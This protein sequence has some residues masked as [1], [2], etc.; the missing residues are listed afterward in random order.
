LQNDPW[1]EMNGKA[2]PPRDESG[3]IETGK[4]AVTLADQAVTALCISEQG[5]TGDEKFKRGL[6][7]ERIYRAKAEVELTI[8]E[9]ALVKEV[10]GKYLNTI[11]LVQIWRAMEGEKPEK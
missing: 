2:V 5:M 10:S 7:A 9:A 6:L 1:L 8:E 11:A 4:P 3:R